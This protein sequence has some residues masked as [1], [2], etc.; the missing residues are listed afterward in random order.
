M[1]ESLSTKSKKPIFEK[2]LLLK[3]INFIGIAKLKKDFYEIT[4]ILMKDLAKSENILIPDF[5]FDLVNVE[6]GNN[7]EISN[8]NIFY[9]KKAEDHLEDEN[10][11]ETIN[12]IK[13]IEKYEIYFFDWLEQAFIYE[14]FIKNIKRI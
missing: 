12:Y 8:K 7:V 1:L 11:Y 9:I 14:D 13:Q 2:L 3:S 5:L 4:N 10:F 6:P